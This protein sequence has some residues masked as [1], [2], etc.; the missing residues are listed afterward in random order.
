MLWLTPRRV[1]LT[2]LP[3]GN[4]SENPAQDY[5]SDGLTEEMIVRLGGPRPHAQFAAGVVCVGFHGDAT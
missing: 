5:F 2:V 3:F 4:L 1:I